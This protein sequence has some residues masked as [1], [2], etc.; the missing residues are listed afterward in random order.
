MRVLVAVATR[1][2]AT[3]EIADMIGAT[4]AGHG[5][6]TDIRAVDEVAGIDG[7]DAVVVGSAVY[8]GSWMKPAREFMERHTEA[9]AGRPTWMFSSGPIGYAPKDGAGAVRIDDLA[10]AVHARGHQVFAGRLDRGRL[11]PVQR[12][13]A[14]MVR[15]ADGDFRDWDAIGDWASEIATELR[16]QG[17]T[18]I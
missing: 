18:L 11:G 9:L 14:R 6:E 1:H 7:Y 10:A 8:M 12:T 15:S 16:S 2:G 17:V 13:I 3:R 5:I 4:I